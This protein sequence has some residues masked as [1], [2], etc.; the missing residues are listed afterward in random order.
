M[1]VEVEK[2]SDRFIAVSSLAVHPD[3]ENKDQGL[4]SCAVAGIVMGS[5]N[6]VLIAVVLAIVVLAV[7]FCHTRRHKQGKL[8]AYLLCKKIIVKPYK[9]CSVS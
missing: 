9:M 8:H 1:G 5:L 2:V 6:L 7:L 3:T 4:E